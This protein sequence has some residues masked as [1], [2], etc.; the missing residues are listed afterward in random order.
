[1]LKGI[2]AVFLLLSSICLIS[3]ENINFHQLNTSDGLSQ[4]IVSSVHQDNKGYLWFGTR[5][6]LN[7]YDGY[8]IK[9]FRKINGDVTSLNS[10]YVV[11]IFEDKY[12]TL[13]VRTKG[14]VHRYDPYKE[15]FT[16]FY[17]KGEPVEDLELTIKDF[18]KQVSTFP[19]HL[20]KVDDVFVMYDRTK[21]NLYRARC[22]FR[23]FEYDSIDNY[24]IDS[25]NVLWMVIINGKDEKIIKYDPENNEIDAIE[26]TE[27][28]HVISMTDDS[29]GN[30]WISTWES[31]LWK[32][33]KE[34]KKL[35]QIRYLG[36]GKSR[37]DISKEIILS[38]FVDDED[39][40]WFTIWGHGLGCINEETGISTNYTHKNGIVNSLAHNVTSYVYQDNTRNIWIGTYGNGL[41][42]FN[43]DHQA[44][45]HYYNLYYDDTS[46]SNNSVYA[47]TETYDGKLWIGTDGGGINIMDRDTGNF[48][49][50]TKN[51]KGLKITSNT[52]VAFLEDSKKRLWIGEWFGNINIY[53]QKT[54]TIHVCDGSSKIYPECDEKVVRVIYEDSQNRIWIGGENKGLTVFY[55]E[56]NQFYYFADEDN[57]I[58]KEMGIVYDIVEDDRRDIWIGTERGLIRYNHNLAK[59]EKYSNDPDDPKSL[60]EDFI[61]TLYYK[62]DCIWIGTNG[63]G[64]NKFNIRNKSFTRLKDIGLPTDVVYGIVELDDYLWLS[65]TNGIIRYD[66]SNN[67]FA[68]FDEEKGLQ[69]KEFNQGAYGITSKQELIFG[70]QNGFNIIAHNK[71]KVDNREPQVLITGF[72]ANG[73]RVPISDPSKEIFEFPHSVKSLKIEFA[74][75]DFT[76]QDKNQY[77]YK[78]LNFN[79]NWVKVNANQRYAQYTNLKPGRYSFQ[80]KASNSDGIWNENGTSL[81][82]KIASPI[83]L[84]WWFKLIYI[85]LLVL[86]VQLILYIKTKVLKAQTRKLEHMVALRNDEAKQHVEKLTAIFNNAVAGIVILNKDNTVQFCNKYLGIMLNKE[87][88][89]LIGSKFT[90]H[91]LDESCRDLQQ[92]LDDLKSGLKTEFH[93]QLKFIREGQGDFWVN[94]SCSAIKDRFNNIDS[95]LA[96]LIDIDARKASEEKIIQLERKSSALA[97]AV[98]AN[99]ELNQP[100]MVLQANLEMLLISFDL[101][102]KT[103]KQSRYLNRIYDSL[104]KMQDILFS[105]KSSSDIDF[106]HFT[107]TNDEVTQEESED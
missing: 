31:G 99:H 98:T 19:F 5:N 75:L 101:D 20:S 57:K 60:S 3:L 89:K 6:G 95:I 74:A 84:T 30:L 39:N 86:I 77:A 47:L 55:P 16:R 13:W 64:L 12:N 65:S 96:I 34:K 103:P 81:V 91:C 38:V 69:G 36:K 59:F 80:V 76:F 2:I 56:T 58:I 105:Y 78:L 61:W 87:D 28:I 7:R 10:N 33:N 26:V 79:E 66:L 63:G 35:E 41:S 24:Y 23:E 85:V 27:G 62:D 71:L 49:K 44:I 104:K 54:K 53:D 102:D 70:G 107:D 52:V 1:M 67:S 42:F 40:V 43:P 21:D 50:I 18:Y 15:N 83:W 14:A 37:I 8:E 90:E 51:S 25:N 72:Y 46:L 29:K 82:F 93:L 94:L 92:E 32:M 48:K 11:C 4:N 45:Q 68:V 17:V 73:E 97:M 9:V 88:K 100:L 106:H 22:K